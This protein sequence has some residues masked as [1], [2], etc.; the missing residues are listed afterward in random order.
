LKFGANF[1][2]LL[3]SSSWTA[4]L[5]KT[6]CSSFSLY[7]SQAITV[8]RDKRAS[9]NFNSSPGLHVAITLKFSLKF[10]SSLFSFVVKVPGIS[11]TRVN[12][13]FLKIIH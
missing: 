11:S 10:L 8:K 7:G 4:E 1:V 13:V 6:T 2:I 5:S 9:D 12:Y 3:I